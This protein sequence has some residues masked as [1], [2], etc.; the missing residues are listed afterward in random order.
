MHSM[1]PAN[2]M[3]QG[4]VSTAVATGQEV[5]RQTLLCQGPPGVVTCK[6][7]NSLLT[8]RALPMRRKSSCCSFES[9]LAP[10]QLAAYAG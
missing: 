9:F 4:A 10:S 5:V 2:S 7:S 3:H 8:A 1:Q 6:K